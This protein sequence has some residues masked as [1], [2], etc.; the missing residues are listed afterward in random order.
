MLRFLIEVSWLGIHSSCYV[1]H[2]K[3][4]KCV[5]YYSLKETDTLHENFVIPF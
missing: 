2:R 1:K 4:L 3:G 5:K